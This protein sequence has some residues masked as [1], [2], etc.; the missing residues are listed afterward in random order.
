[1]PIFSKILER[2][3]HDQLYSYVTKY[4]ILNKS[5][6][7]FRKKH[8]TTTALLSLLD[9][10]YKLIDDG[11]FVCMVLLDF[12]KAFDTVNHKLLLDK[13]NLYG[14]QGASNNWFK[15]Y[16][17]NRFQ[18]VKYNSAISDKCI[19]Q[20]G[21]PQGSI[22]G[23]LLFTL[24]IN[25]ITKVLK[26]CLIT[27]FADDANI[28]YAHNSTEAI[29]HFVNE[30][31]SCIDKWLC[32][33][34]LSLN[35]AKTYS[36]VCRSVHYMNKEININLQIRGESITQVDSCKYLGMKIDKCLN[37]NDHVS[38]VCKKAG[39]KLG[40]LYRTRPYVNQYRSLMLYKSLILPI[41]DY[42]DCLL[43]ALSQ[44]NAFKLQKIQNKALR[45]IL[46]SDVY[47]SVIYLHQE[48]NLLTLYERRNYHLAVM[49]YK[50]LTDKAPGYLI[51][52]LSYVSSIHPLNT[53]A[54]QENDLY[55]SRARHA[56]GNKAFSRL[57][58]KI[59]NELPSN[60]RQSTSVISFKMAYLHN[61]G[62][63]T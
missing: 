51:D 57:G 4:D 61:I 50:C 20:C 7:G 60:V 5:Q 10:V 42:G 15:D 52:R 18:V 25:D 35:I 23:P 63:R 32:H 27:L 2:A 17:Y 46:R 59:F 13:L 31:L 54:S 43:T 49:T 36:L 14:I 21:V 53:R 28:C 24:Y 55:I 39:H 8:S 9:D 33:N 48:L 3:V 34:K 29:E 47:R 41:L 22:L 38:Y 16:L 26:N 6:S 58:P 30:D 37:F 45:I 12:R 56:I 1:M 44:Q 62:I 40:L 19:V 11:K